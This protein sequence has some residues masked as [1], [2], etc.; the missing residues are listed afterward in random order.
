MTTYTNHLPPEFVFCQLTG[1]NSKKQ[2][3]EFI[4]KTVS[5]ADHRLNEA[6]IQAALLNR[7]QLGSTA[8][9]YGVAIPHAR[10]SH[11]PKPMVVC[12][13]V[14][15]PIDFDSDDRFMVDI[16][17]GLLVPELATEEHLGILSD[18]SKQLLEPEFRD[19]LRRAQDAESL[20][21]VLTGDIEI[22]VA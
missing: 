12:L 15:K 4:S 11:L 9:G 16:I 14:N 8:I 19:S 3:I 17:F 5:D 7:E 20:Y 18:L 6:E 22:A 21:A 10:I 1:I 2:A 13:T